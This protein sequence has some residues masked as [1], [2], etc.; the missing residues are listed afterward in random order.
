MLLKVYKIRS[1][2][3]EEIEFFQAKKLTKTK[4]NFKIINN[5]SL[6]I[7]NKNNKNHTS[8]KSGWRVQAR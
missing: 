7:K 5:F 4:K 6:E 1:K 2:K 8:I 3:K